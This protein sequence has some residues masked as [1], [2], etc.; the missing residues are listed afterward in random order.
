MTESGQDGPWL[1]E[2]PRQPPLRLLC[3]LTVA[4]LAVAGAASAWLAVAFAQR[5]A[6]DF[7]I[8]RGKG[9]DEAAGKVAGEEDKAEYTGE[10]LVATILPFGVATALCAAVFVAWHAAVDQAAREWAGGLNTERWQALG[11]W[12]LP[13]ANLLLPFRAMRELAEVHRAQTAARAMWVWWAPWAVSLLL[14]TFAV[15]AAFPWSPFYGGD[16]D[17]TPDELADLDN[18]GVIVGS[19]LAVAAVAA[20]VLVLSLTAAV[21]GRFGADQD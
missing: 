3:A 20:I 21:E 8:Y 7:R 4:G 9:F 2:E 12:F 15:N 11:G 14:G 10:F 19:G 16:T 1:D 6:D 18:Y 5:T 17:P 13:V